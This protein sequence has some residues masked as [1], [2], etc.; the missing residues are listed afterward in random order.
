M[1][2]NPRYNIFLLGKTS[3]MLE[4]LKKQGLVFKDEDS[5]NLFFESFYQHLEEVFDKAKELGF[6]DGLDESKNAMEELLE[7]YKTLS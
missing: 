6:S 3:Q 2:S 1:R 5:K 7:S 4:K